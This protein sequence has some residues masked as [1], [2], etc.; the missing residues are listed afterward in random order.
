VFCS[1]EIPVMDLAR[2]TLILIKRVS[3]D[4][5]LKRDSDGFDK[6]LEIT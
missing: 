3:L 4:K 6:Y 2:R 1:S 5:S